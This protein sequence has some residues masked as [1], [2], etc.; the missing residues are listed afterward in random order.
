MSIMGRTIEICENSSR[1]TAS[2][3]VVTPQCYGNE[4]THEVKVIYSE[5]HFGCRADEDILHLCLSCAERVKKDAR[6]HGY[7][8]KVK[9]IRTEKGEKIA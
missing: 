9:R 2:S 4:S 8:V 6:R 1:G 7:A 5:D 3:A